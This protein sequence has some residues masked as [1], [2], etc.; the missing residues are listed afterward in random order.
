MAHQNAVSKACP[1]AAAVS[2]WWMRSWPLWSASGRSP[3]QT[4]GARTRLKPR[5]SRLFRCHRVATV[6]YQ[7]DI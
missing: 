2:A 6:R 4:S 5:Q 1:R 3:W 7:G